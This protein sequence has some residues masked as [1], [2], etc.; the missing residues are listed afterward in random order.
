MPRELGLSPE[1]EPIFV[2]LGPF[3]PYIK[4][5][6][7][8]VPLPKESDPYTIQL[9]TILPIIASAKELR[10]KQLKP[11]AELGLDPV[12]KKNILIKEGRFGPYITD[13]KTNVSVKKNQNI[14]AITTEEAIEL[15]AKKR[16]A[17]KRSWGRRKG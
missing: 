3:G 13:G 16:A 10:Q 2:T 11:L 7:T 8:N 5:G 1:G 12:S 14:S 6:G 4:V 9:D 15:L 17:P